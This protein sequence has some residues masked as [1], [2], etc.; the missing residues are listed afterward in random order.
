MLRTAPLFLKMKAFDV[1]EKSC[2]PR[3]RERLWSGKLVGPGQPLAHDRASETA[4]IS[5]KAQE[6][7]ESVPLAGVP[8]H[9]N[10][11]NRVSKS[12]RPAER[13]HER[14]QNPIAALEKKHFGFYTSVFRKSSGADRRSEPVFA[15]EKSLLNTGRHSVDLLLAEWMKMEAQS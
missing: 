1:R 12:L 11:E 13:P 4:K 7:T 2:R 10:A 15:T 8:L 3:G 14:P 6:G 9:K 5:L